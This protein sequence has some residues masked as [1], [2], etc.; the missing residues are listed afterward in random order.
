MGSVFTPV[1]KRSLTNYDDR[2]G[3]HDGYSNKPGLVR[4]ARVSESQFCLEG[5]QYGAPNP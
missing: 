5:I 1:R 3:D 4:M 2:N